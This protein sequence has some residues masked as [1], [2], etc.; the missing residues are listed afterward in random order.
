MKAIIVG[1]SGFTGRKLIDL[2][3][4]DEQITKVYALL[5]HKIDLTHDQLVQVLVDFENLS[6]AAITESCDLAFCCLGSTIRKAG[7]K[8]NFRKVDFDYV[9]AFAKLC[10]QHAVSDFHFISAIGAN[11]KSIFFYQ[12]IKGEVEQFIRTQSF[13]SVVIYRPSVIY[14][15]RKEFRPFEAFA[16][17]ISRNL[18]FHFVGKLKR[19]AAVTGDQ[20]ATTIYL[21]SKKRVVGCC[22][23]ESE[24]ISQIQ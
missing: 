4:Q 18:Y 23:I 22:I 1:G 8:D 14:G 19:I 2:L 10:E 6:F 12:R 16:A 24:K 13:N 21:E 17:W 7:T 3:L 15:N 9:L 20:L 11:P 5:R